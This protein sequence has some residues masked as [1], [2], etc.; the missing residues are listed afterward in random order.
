MALSKGQRSVEPLIAFPETLGST[1]QRRRPVPSAA[2]F[3]NIHNAYPFPRTGSQDASYDTASTDG[4][5]YWPWDTDRDLHAPSTYD[6]DTASSDSIG[7]FEDTDQGTHSTGS[8]PII[9]PNLS[10]EHGGMSCLALYFDV[11]QHKAT[12]DTLQAFYQACALW[13]GEGHWQCQQ[14]GDEL[15]EEWWNWADALEE[16]NENCGDWV[17]YGD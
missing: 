15:L 12:L 11:K 13:F 16:W 14:Y 9:N 10:G 3:S 2:I 8:G 17:G 6:S 5:D 4:E 7:D 1:R